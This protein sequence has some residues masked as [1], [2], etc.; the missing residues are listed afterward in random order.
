[1]NEYRQ[2]VVTAEQKWYAD[3]HQDVVAAVN[4]K[5]KDI[6]FLHDIEISEKADLEVKVG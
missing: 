5:N 1:M 4:L 3:H 2:I 6:F